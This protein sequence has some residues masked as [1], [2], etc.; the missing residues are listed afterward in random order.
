MPT[1]FNFNLRCRG[2]RVFRF[3]E[4]SASPSFSAPDAGVDFFDLVVNGRA[5]KDIWDGGVRDG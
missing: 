3:S 1:P 4:I 2:I 5:G